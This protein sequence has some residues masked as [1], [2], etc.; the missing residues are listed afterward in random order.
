MGAQEAGRETADRPDPGRARRRTRPGGRLP[1]SRSRPRGRQPRRSAATCP[2][3][4]TRRARAWQRVPGA[5]PSP[6]PWWRAGP[7]RTGARPAVL[8][9]P[10][11]RGHSRS[12]RQAQRQA[13]APGGPRPYQPVGS[14]CARLVTEK[15]SACGLPADPVRPGV[16]RRGREAG[17]AEAASGVAGLV[18]AE[19]LEPVR[20]GQVGKA[21]GL[22]DLVAAVLDPVQGGVES[23]RTSWSSNRTSDHQSQSKSRRSSP[24]PSTVLASRRGRFRV[25]DLARSMP[26][27]RAISSPVQPG[28]TVPVSEAGRSG[29]RGRRPGRRNSGPSAAATAGAGER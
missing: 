2:A 14:R 11:T 19:G 28:R 1:R 27:C 6:P 8:P 20:G 10:G 25:S 21:E 12:A 24:R 18:G 15:G 16:W 17:V 26:R 22:V 3:D 4:R 7:S 5:G 9:P 29:L 13:P 23:I